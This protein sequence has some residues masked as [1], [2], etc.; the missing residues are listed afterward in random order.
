MMH[1]ITR[2]T[3]IFARPTVGWS[4]SL[5]GRGRRSA[6]PPLVNGTHVYVREHDVMY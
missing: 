1:G 4:W 6:P 3:H 2:P 5:S